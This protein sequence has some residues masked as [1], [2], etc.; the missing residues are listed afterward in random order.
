MARVPAGGAVNLPRLPSPV[1]VGRDEALGGLRGA[2]RDGPGVIAQAVVGLGGIGKS[3]LALQYADRRRGDY[4]LVW[5]VLAENADAVQAGLADLC[6]ALCAPVASA[7]AA[8]APAPEAA[9]WALAWLAAHDRWLV[10]FDNA[11]DVADLEPLLGRLRSGHVLVTSRRTVG[12]D[13][14]GTVLRLPVLR[15]DDAVDLLETLTGPAGGAGDLAEELGGLPLALRQAGAYI[16]A[17]PGMTVR[18]Y[19][20]RLRESAH[21]AVSA[22]PPHGFGR[23]RSDQQVV[24][25]VWSVTMD[26]VRD[27]HPL[28]GQV[29][30]LLACFAPDRLPCDVLYGLPDTDPVEV[31]EALA[32]LAS[33]SMVEL[34]ADQRYVSVH[35]LVQAVTRAA[36]TDAD[37]EHDRTMA[38]ELIRKALPDTPKAI[39]SWPRWA[40]LLPHVR[41][42]LDPAS[43]AMAA[44][45]EY[46]SASGNYRAGLELQR[47]ATTALERLHGPEH[48][49][50]LAS[51]ANLGYWTGATGDAVGA[52]DMYAALLPVR[53]RM[54]GAEHPSALSTRANLARWTGEAGDAAAARD[55]FAALLPISERVL[56]AE[57]PNTLSARAYLASWT[58]RAGDA[59]AAR[60]MFA[61]L[62]PVS[63]RVRGPEHHQTVTARANLAFW[64]GA[65]GDTAG[66]RD[67]F[68]A[69]L[70]I[71]ERTL[72]PEHPETLTARANLAG[73]TGDAGD[74]VAARDMFAALVPVRERVLGAEHPE[75]LVA[76]A[77]LA[78]WTGR[79]GDMGA[80]RDLYAGLLP[81]RERV[82]GPEHP[83]TLSARAGLAYWTGEAGDAGAARDLY[84]AL[85]PVRERV[86]GPEHPDTLTTWAN[87]AQWTGRAGDAVA[88][89]DHYVELVP[90]RERVLGAEHPH[91]LTARRRLAYWAKWAARRDGG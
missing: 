63:E 15:H 65:T 13:A 39:E 46:L 82:L 64:T 24:A 72:G 41:A 53:M 28:A 91:T 70:P 55:M 56:G 54:A 11:E 58:G 5:W 79:A 20:G 27:E 44:V 88:A 43:D 9:A 78:H 19:A 1:F 68:A 86:L 14:I 33:Y 22:R 50:T 17:V 77:G 66:A 31:G 61:A 12:W 52:R 4:D 67:M 30:R 2:V 34:S 38:A 69:L 62:L 89:R 49:L 76:R 32:A 87:L 48:P 57:H 23:R 45:L 36:L 81:V 7:A 75:T 6:R 74:A 40:E 18:T 29:M 73:W 3:E 83:D 80:A 10:V 25:A 60:E 26:R 90:V 42:A 8:Q 47:L 21:W 37:H 16:A 35:R 71:S 59:V 84:A 85:L 51:H